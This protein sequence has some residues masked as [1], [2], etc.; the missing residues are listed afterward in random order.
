MRPIRRILSVVVLFLLVLS[1]T[2]V[3]AQDMLRTQYESFD[4]STPEAAVFTFVDR[5]QSRDYVGLF[6]IFAPQTQIAVD[7]SF[8]NFALDNLIQAE[9]GLAEMV[10]AYTVGFDHKETEHGPFANT[11]FDEIMLYAEERDAFLIDLRGEV[12]ILRSE[13]STIQDDDE[14]FTAVDVFASVEGI[15]SEVTF[16]MV[17]SP[18]GRWRVLQVITPGGDER[19][20]P[21]AVSDESASTENTRVT[22]LFVDG[23]IFAEDNAAQ[24]GLEFQFNDPIIDY[25]TP[26]EAQVL[27]LEAGLGSFL[28]DALADHPVGAT[29]YENTERYKRQYLGITFEEDKPLIYANFFCGDSF[30]YWLEA[31]VS[32]EDGGECFFQV[33]Y[34]PETDT[35]SNLR[36]NG[37]A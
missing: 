18:S 25:W 1:V 27:A 22:S 36:V 35:F 31:L 16:R 29:I 14:E 15:D 19:F 17:Q 6:M 8:V 7:R 23:I 2:L 32:V 21:W 24:M 37:E 33:M 30:D 10:D 3:T 12:E 4:L 11:M 26:T 34:D 20:L 13:E 28:V 5:F 9:T